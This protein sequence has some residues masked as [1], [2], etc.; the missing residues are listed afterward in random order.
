MGGRPS[1]KGDR[2]FLEN[3]D[4][5][6]GCLAQEVDSKIPL[7]L[8]DLACFSRLNTDLDLLCEAFGIAVSTGYG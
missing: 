5:I 4:E 8:A 2:V 6:N 3:K 7:K 1:T